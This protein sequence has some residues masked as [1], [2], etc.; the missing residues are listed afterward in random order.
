MTE[1]DRFVAL[2]LAMT[3][4]ESPNTRPSR[5]PPGWSAPDRGSASIL[6][7]SACKSLSLRRGEA[8][9]D[10]LLLAQQARDQF[11]VQLVPLRVRRSRNSRRSSA[12]S[13]RSI[14]LPFH[15]RGDG[16]ADGRFMGPGALGDVL[17]AAGVVAEAERRQHA[18]LRNVE[19]VTRLIFDR[20]RGAD[21]GRE[22]VE[23]ERHELEEVEPAF[24]LRC[25]LL[26]R[27]G[28]GPDRAGLR[29]AEDALAKIAP[30]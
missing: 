12:F 14:D 30:I 7:S 18:P 6:P 1:M 4:R 2:L 24:F 15:Q 11:L 20:E 3:W 10:F 27:V 17:R 16:A 22:P 25:A 26:A 13:T 29:F 5:P 8:R 21:L 28:A 9:Q 23:A 19:P